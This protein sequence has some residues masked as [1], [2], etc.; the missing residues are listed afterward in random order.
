ML[1]LIGRPYVPANGLVIVHELIHGKGV[2]EEEVVKLFDQK[3][4]GQKWENWQVH[5]DLLTKNS[6][7]WLTDGV[8]NDMVRIL[9][10][11]QSSGNGVI[12]TDTYY[13]TKLMQ[14]RSDY[15]TKQ[16]KFNYKEVQK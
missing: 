16:D 10:T 5:I 3:Y 2:P 7:L 11:L 13:Y 14:L 9:T 4:R 6:D 1:L 8:M 15:P 12:F